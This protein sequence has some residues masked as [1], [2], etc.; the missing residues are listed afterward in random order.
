MKAIFI[1]PFPPT[2]ESFNSISINED[3]LKAPNQINSKGEKVF[4]FRQDW[5]GIIGEHVMLADSSVRW[6]VWRPDFRADK[7]MTH[8]FDDNLVCKSFPA[9]N[10]IT[11]YG[12]T[13][14]KL[15][16]SIKLE[17][18]LISELN[19]DKD[20]RILL[21]TTVDFSKILHARIKR[22]TTHILYYHFLNPEFLFPQFDFSK[23]PLKLLHRVLINHQ[24]ALRLKFI[25]N[26]Q[27][28]SEE[29]KDM[30]Q[31][32]YPGKNILLARIGIDLNYWQNVLSREEARQIL[33]WKNDT[34]VFLL[35]QRLVSEYQVDK[36][37][38]ALAKVS[39]R[40]YLCIITG[41]GTKGYIEY[42]SSVIRKSGLDEKIKL[43]GFV[44]NELLRNYLIA[45]DC[46]VMAGKKGGGSTGA[47]YAMHMSRLVFHTDSGVSCEILK[48]FGAGVIAQPYDYYTWP[49]IIDGILADKNAYKLVPPDFIDDLFNWGICAKQ[50]QD[51]L[52]S[53]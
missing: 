44:P 39:A 17:E 31:R 36:W 19:T 13:P 18:S 9:E 14:V 15:P 35:S 8:S 33:G 30:A 45:C 4:F 5:G 6:E 53:I 49:G 52:Q 43:V 7:I 20:I 32:K 24:K 10:R 50:W 21:P 42:L 51:A 26:L 41:A 16:Y 28:L 40:N 12:L 46:F 47:I 22:F 23:N 48:K 2:Y 3:E 34:F 37:I 25:M 29:L 11:F 27:V 1:I 38:E